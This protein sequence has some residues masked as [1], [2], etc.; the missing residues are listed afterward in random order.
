MFSFRRLL[1]FDTVATSAR[2][3][4]TLKSARSLHW[5]TSRSAHHSLHNTT[6]HRAC[7]ALISIVSVSAARSLIERFAALQC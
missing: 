7:V 5:H 4:S 1:G 2:M 6:Q 3:M